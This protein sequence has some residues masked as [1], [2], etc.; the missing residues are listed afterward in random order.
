MDRRIEAAIAI[1]HIETSRNVS[2]RELARR[3]NLSVW[4]FARLFKAETS[5]SPKQYMRD[6]K[7]KQAA[8]MLAKSF[9]SIKEIATNVGLGDRSHFSRTYKKLCGH[10]PSLVRVRRGNDSPSKPASTRAE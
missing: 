4:H 1:V 9:L 3:V 2:V 10:A 5:I 7:V 8:E 6:Y